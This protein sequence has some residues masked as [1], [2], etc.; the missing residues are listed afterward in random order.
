MSEDKKDVY[1]LYC[2]HNWQIIIPSKRLEQCIHCSKIRSFPFYPYSL[3]E[4]IKEE[5]K[6]REK[7]NG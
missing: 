7:D 3:G 6:Q 2:D 1:G 5:K 4:I